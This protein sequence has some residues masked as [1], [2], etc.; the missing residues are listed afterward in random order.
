MK[1]NPFTIKMITVRLKTLG[2]E[3]AQFRQSMGT[4]G[5]WRHYFYVTGVPAGSDFTGPA[6]RSEEL[7]IAAKVVIDEIGTKI[8]AD[9]DGADMV[10][11]LS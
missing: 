7:M 2:W 6:E 10:L 4:D 5:R 3:V 1:I 8:D 9:S 11:S